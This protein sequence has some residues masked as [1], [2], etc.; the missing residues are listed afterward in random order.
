MIEQW[1]LKVREAYLDAQS[2]RKDA[3][4]SIEERVRLLHDAFEKFKEIRSKDVVADERLFRELK[5]RF[6]SEWGFGVFFDGG[7]GAERGARAAA[8]RGPRRPRAR[9]ARHDPHVQ[10]P[11]AAARDQAAEGRLGVPRVRQPPRVDDPRRRP[12][13]SAG[14]A[15]DGPARRW[16]LRDLRPERPVPPRDQPQQP[17]QAAARSR[18]ARDHREQREAHAAGGRRRPVRQRA[19]RPRGDGPG[20]PAAQV[21]LRHAQG[22]AG[23]LPPEPARQARRLLGPL[24]DRVGPAAQAAPVRPAEAD[25]ARAVQAVHHEPAGRPQGRP[26][27][28]G[29]QEDGRLDGTRSCGTSSTRSSRSTRCC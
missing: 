15:P 16:A 10:G 13:D 7:M 2:R 24:R 26:E 29:G 22:Q 11:E 4:E 18:R 12:G 9:A 19:P 3:D 1:A 21:A 25:G 17:P 20:Q 23:S 8:P 28:Q 6:G 14:A 5:D 27:H